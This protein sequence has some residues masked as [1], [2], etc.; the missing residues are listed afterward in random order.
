ME[1]WNGWISYHSSTARNVGLDLG[2][3]AWDDK[4]LSNKCLLSSKG[5]CVSI[6]FTHH[7]AFSIRDLENQTAFGGSFLSRRGGWRTWR[8]KLVTHSD[9][10][11]RRAIDGDGRKKFAQIAIVFLVIYRGL[12]NQLAPAASFLGLF[13]TLTPQA[14]DSMV[15]FPTWLFSFNAPIENTEE[16]LSSSGLDSLNS[17]SGCFCLYAE[18]TSRFRRNIS[19]VEVCYVLLVAMNFLR[20]WGYLSES[21]HVSDAT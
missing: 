21:W 16:E 19:I 2:N 13:P 8:T 20:A 4:N 11:T 6:Y 18:P 3:I 9:E 12:R 17:Q 1:I 15:I 7:I 14:E 10:Q 5:S